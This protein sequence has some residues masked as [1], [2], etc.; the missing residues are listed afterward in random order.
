LCAVAFYLGF[1]TPRWLRQVWQLVELRNYLLGYVQKF[2]GK[3]STEILDRLCLA[4]TQAIGFSVAVVA[5]RDKDNEQLVLQKTSES[6][7]I[8]DFDW[9][10]EGV[11]KQVWRDQKQA[12]VY[13][14]AQLSSGDTGLMQTLDAETLLIVP[15]A[16]NERSL[17][18]LLVFLQHGSLFVDDDV[19]LLTIFA[20]Q[21]AI[22]LENSIVLDELHHYAEGLEYKVEKRTAELRA[23]EAELRNLNAELEQRVIERT[24]QLMTVNRELEAFSYSVSHDLRAPLR[25]MNGFSLALVDD[26]ADRLDD[27]GKRYLQRIQTASER[28]GQLIDD[29]LQLSR[30]A[31]SEIQLEQVNLSALA[32]QI[33]ADLQERQPERQAQFDI[34]KELVVNGDMRLLRVMLTN[35]LENA[36]KFTGKESDTRI[37]F[38]KA[39][40][41]GHHAYF[42][43]DNG[44]GFDMAYADKL[45][46][47]F[48]RLHTEQE[49]KGIGIGLAI[50]QRVVHRH[51]GQI[52]AEAAVGEGATF[53]FTLS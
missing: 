13:K 31:R 12:V 23:S 3:T 44:A 20:Q 43:R 8:A 53:Y 16:T 39:Q 1:A 28:M 26:Y 21:T 22:V 52:W 41:N 29:L 45:F 25:A 18:L 24:A 34:E 48:Q 46:G 32:N 14:T 47:A 37:A 7:P 10:A 2:A 36:W 4:V 30:L 33:V 49:F 40:H 15:I 38:G 51:N 11:V 19:N 35:L 42:V 50:V 6:T 27:D 5:L 17:G 9:Q